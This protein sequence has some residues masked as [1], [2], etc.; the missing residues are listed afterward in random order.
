MMIAS[1]YLTLITPGVNY[2]SPLVFHFFIITHSSSK[3]CFNENITHFS[4]FIL[5]LMV[6]G[7][8]SSEAPLVPVFCVLLICRLFI[9][10][11][12]FKC[13]YSSSSWIGFC[14]IGYNA[15]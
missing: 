4:H 14:S 2:A 3:I 8:C 13:E 5:I 6:L 12:L 9:R 7:F 1:S 11:V 15:F 10:T